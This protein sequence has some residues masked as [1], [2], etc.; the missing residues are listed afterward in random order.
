MAE[1]KYRL[2]PAIKKETRNISIYCLIGFVLLVGIFAVLHF[3]LYENAPFD[4]TVFLGAGVGCIVAIL[5]FFLM[6]VTVQEVTKQEDDKEARRIMKTSYTKRMGLQLFWM[7]VAIAAPCFQWAAGLVPLLFPTLGIKIKGIIDFK[8]ST[9]K[10]NEQ[11]V[12]PSKDDH[13]GYSNQ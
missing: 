8:R 13:S 11:E 2:Q 12:E 1:S 6:C 5:N 10:Y 9:P 3:F 7:V 4:Y